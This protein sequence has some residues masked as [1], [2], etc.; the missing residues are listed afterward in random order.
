MSTEQIAFSS[1]RGSSRG[2]VG[3]SHGMV[4]SGHSLAAAAALQVL[5]SGGNA[6]D[7]G[8]AASAVQSV[9]EM[10]WCGLGGDAFWLVYTPER[11]VVACNGNGITPRGLHKGL[12]AGTK[13]APRFGPLSVAVP[14]LASTWQTL[15]EG[16]ASRPLAKLLEPAIAYASEGSRCIH[17]WNMPSPSSQTWQ[18]PGTFPGRKRSA[19]R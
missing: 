7:A 14:G 13:R 5:Q 6:V 15:S 2:V 19:H 9:V 16:F 10:P 17:A 12:L 8:L 18:T 1:G 4:S 11:G 3:G